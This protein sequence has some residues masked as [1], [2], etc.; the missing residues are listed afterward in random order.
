MA[1]LRDAQSSQILAEGTPIEMVLLADRIGHDE[2]LFDD[3]G[4]A[5]DP[6]AV[7]RA[8]QAQADGLERAAAEASGREAKQLAAA[9]DELRGLTEAADVAAPAAIAALDAARGALER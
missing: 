5:F 2:V 4:P 3:V 7:R 1:Q 9:H 6:D 8:H